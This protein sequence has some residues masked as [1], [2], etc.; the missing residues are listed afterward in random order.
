MNNNCTITLRNIQKFI[1]EKFQVKICE[2]TVRN[3]LR[4]LHYN[5][6]MLKLIPEKRNDTKTIELRKQYVLL[7]DTL[8]DEFSDFN[9]FLLMRLDSTYP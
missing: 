7:F 9:I 3:N 6:K 1:L 5:L 8:G 4:S 2:A